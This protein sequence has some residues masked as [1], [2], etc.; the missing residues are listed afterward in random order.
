MPPRPTLNGLQESKNYNDGM[1][2]QLE[3]QVANA[4]TAQARD[5]A[6]ARL[7]EG[8]DNEV[9][10]EASRTAVVEKLDDPSFIA[11]F[12]NNGGEE[13]LSYLNIGESLVVEGGEPWQKWD[14]KV[15]ANLKRV[16]NG[17]GSWTGHHCITGRNFCTAT[18]L[19]VLLTDRM[20][21]PSATA[22][23]RK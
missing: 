23:A 16:Q 22:L 17:D 19:L 6:Q 13:F 7:R 10:L 21:L 5:A 9:K 8:R 3:Q 1:R 11:G 12:G 14:E 4:P 20:T 15:G 18:A 2:Q